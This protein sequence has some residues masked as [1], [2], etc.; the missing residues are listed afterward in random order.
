M[1]WFVARPINSSMG[2]FECPTVQMTPRF[3][4]VEEY[5]LGQVCVAERRNPGRPIRLPCI[6][7]PTV[8]N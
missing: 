4:T 3:L 2:R 1:D 7:W 6:Q 8:Q 5:A